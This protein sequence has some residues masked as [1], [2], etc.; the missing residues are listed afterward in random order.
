[1]NVVSTGP[2]L[3]L[4]SRPKK[5]TK[6]DLPRIYD[7]GRRPPDGSMTKTEWLLDRRCRV[8]N[9]ARP[10]A[11]L[12]SI[13]HEPYTHRTRWCPLP[14]YEIDELRGMLLDSD[15]PGVIPD[16]A[17]AR[18][19]RAWNAKH[20]VEAYLYAESEVVPIGELTQAQAATILE[21]RWLCPGSSRQQ[22]IEAA[23][24][25]AAD[26]LRT[27]TF[28]LPGRPALTSHRNGRRHQGLRAG[29]ASRLVIFDGDRH[30]G[31]VPL[32]EHVLRVRG[33]LGHLQEKY[34]ATRP[35][36][37]NVNPANASCHVAGY[38]PRCWGRDKIACWVEALREEFPWLRQWQVYPVDLP[39]V[40]L[41]LRIDKAT[42]IDGPLAKATHKV[43]I[44]GKMKKVLGHD[45]VA[46]LEWLESDKPC[47]I[48]AVEGTLRRAAVPDAPARALEAH[49][50]AGKA[51]KGGKGLTA[52]GS[53]RGKERLIQV[54]YWEGRL[55]PSP[56]EGGRIM[57]FA[58]RYLV[59]AEGFAAE[60]AVDWV[61][62]GVDRLPDSSF[63][64]RLSKPNGPEL[65]RKSLLV[66]SRRY[67]KDN[68]W[69][70]D[71]AASTEKLLAAKAAWDRIG[72]VLS[73]RSTW[74]SAGKGTLP[75][76]R[77]VW[78]GELADVLPR[79]AE[80]AACTEEKAAE[81]AEEV[82]TH[83]AARGELS[84]T[85]LGFV[86]KRVGLKS[87]A[88]KQVA[89]R[90]CLENTGVI[91]RKRNGFQDR[92]TGTRR[93]SV[94]V[95]GR[96]A[97]FADDAEAAAAASPRCPAGPVQGVQENYTNP[98]KA[99]PDAPREASIYPSFLVPVGLRADGLA[100]WITERRSA[101]NQQ[102]DEADVHA[103]AA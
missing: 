72:F 12:Y 80:A 83:V 11:I 96:V 92:T 43:K 26:E 44:D 87:Y 21:R 79:L 91:V 90:S 84:L 58:L 73:D 78:E 53:H 19:E 29:D 86:L 97:R 9:K 39:Q 46:Y 75:R 38:I 85:Y 103:E 16:E 71:P 57:T 35:H 55:V 1:M 64:L 61:M 27:T 10:L 3:A 74:N 56:G 63:I 25:D 24:V 30:G 8:L 76:R 28:S 62:D 65:L 7:Q 70:R 14:A 69:Q 15:D 42:V 101:R 68:G 51:T 2:V 6:D 54:D 4:R 67:E 45:W 36:A 20:V 100:K 93:G 31:C 99:A 22:H 5:F 32:G 47:D 50:R 49:E 89:V 59:V 34:A 66:Q 18:L 94:Y 23:E 33:L 17:A 88:N 52:G 102:G 41:P 95:L 13:Y 98:P 81:L 37:T 48:D 77:L 40:Y 60:E 82:A